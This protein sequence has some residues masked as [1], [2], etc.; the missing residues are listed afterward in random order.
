[1]PSLLHIAL[2]IYRR[3]FALFVWLKHDFLNAPLASAGQL[4]ASCLL[5]LNV[6]HNIVQC[7]QMP[8]QCHA[9]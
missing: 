2:E 9:I 4:Q 6:D 1:M 5:E 3:D 7:R 8:L